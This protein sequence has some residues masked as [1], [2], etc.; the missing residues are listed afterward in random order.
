MANLQ[1]AV[2]GAY[3]DARSVERKLKSIAFLMTTGRN[4]LLTLKIAGRL[5]GST[6]G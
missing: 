3:F 4:A 1:L 2:K 5:E 6:N